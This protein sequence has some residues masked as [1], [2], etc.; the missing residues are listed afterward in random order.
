MINSGKSQKVFFGETTSD[1]VCVLVSLTSGFVSIASLYEKRMLKTCCRG[2]LI[3]KGDL[4]RF[5]I[6]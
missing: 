5:I 1:F 2:T 4:L 3:T 6:Y